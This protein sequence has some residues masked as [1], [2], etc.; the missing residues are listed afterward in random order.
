M[1]KIRVISV[2]ARIKLSARAALTG[3]QSRVVP[4]AAALTA[5]FIAFSVCN[6]VVNGFSVFHGKYMPAVFAALSL[7]VFTLAVSVLEFFFQ[8]RLILQFRSLLKFILKGFSM[9]RL[10][11][12]LEFQK[13]LLQIW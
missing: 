2:N 3:S 1:F 13:S 4:F 6:A 10:V 11:K 5:V 12:R 8:I 9:L 7:A